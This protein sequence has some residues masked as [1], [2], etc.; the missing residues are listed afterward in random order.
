MGENAT[1]SSLDISSRATEQATPEVLLS[2]SISL[3]NALAMS[4]DGKTLYFGDATGDY[5]ASFD[6]QSQRARYI[7]NS[8]HIFALDVYDGYIYWS[9]WTS[10]VHK[11]PVKGGTVTQLAT[12]SDVYRASGIRVFRPKD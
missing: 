5:V 3:P 1:I 8:T 7:T 11:M 2:T 4:K 10:G 12:L 9:D 6:L